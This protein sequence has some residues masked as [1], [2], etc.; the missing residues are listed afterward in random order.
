MHRHASSWWIAAFLLSF[1]LGG[2]ADTHFEAAQHHLQD[3]QETE[4]RRALELEIA[5][6]PNNL[7]ARYNLAVLLERI[8]HDKD[9]AAL[10]RENL[11]RGRHL[12][13][14]VNLSAWLRRQGRT[15]EARKL[16]QQATQ[17]YPAEAVPWYLLADMAQQNG[18]KQQAAGLF[19]EAIKADD[20][21]GYAH[22]RFARFL[23]SS[24][25]ISKAV[26]QADQ[27]VRL[28]PECAPCLDITGD[29]FSQAGK[30]RRA[31]ALWQRS[32][33]IE[34][35]DALR[36]KIRQALKTIR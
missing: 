6:R 10:Y 19:R 29:I 15:G 30:K 35:N 18:N 3:G 27:A 14:V 23:A 20:K 16:L 21:N 5:S 7:Q 17:D 13:S 9:A 22:L 2:C 32:I 36:S 24:G 8:G 28:L 12:A 1:P 25:D 26:A 11:K 34:P 31:L 33:A 4:A